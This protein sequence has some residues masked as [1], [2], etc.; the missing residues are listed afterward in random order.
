MKCFWFR[1]LAI[2]CSTTVF[3][4]LHPSCFALINDSGS[5]RS[6]FGHERAVRG[7]RGSARAKGFQSQVSA[8]LVTGNTAKSFSG[9]NADIGNVNILEQHNNAVEKPVTLTVVVGAAD[10]LLGA[11][12]AKRLQASLKLTVDDLR[13]TQLLKKPSITSVLQ[14]VATVIFLPVLSERK[15]M[16]GWLS[17]S[18]FSLSR[19]EN[20]ML[21]DKDVEEF[22]KVGVYILLIQT[23]LDA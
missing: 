12:I 8:A 1:I 7:W 3:Q 13:S 4:C 15:G 22:L 18:L 10:T 2:A 20:S 11:S 16:E 14:N 23:T 6:W 5:L 17:T 9:G 19:R 21:Q